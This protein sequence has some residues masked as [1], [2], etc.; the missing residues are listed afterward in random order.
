MTQ[1]MISISFSADDLATI[2]A[3]VGTLEE[4]LAGLI[5]LSV[6]ERRGLNKMGD[7]TEAA[8]RQTLIV[9]A[10]NPQILPPSFD[11]A[12]AER[13]LAAFDQLRPLAV[14]IKQLA[15]RVAD[16]EMALGS[17]ILSSALEGYAIAKAAGKGAA[18]DVMRESMS[19][20]YGHRRKASKPAV[21]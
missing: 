9:L 10:Q 17:D 15:E 6:D 19:A 4:K 8:C 5:E 12:E 1:N 14:R 16:T 3:A 20:R 11:F 2:H 18:L 21:V 13:D 7:K